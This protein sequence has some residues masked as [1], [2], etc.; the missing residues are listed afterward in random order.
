M[1]FQDCSCSSTLTKPISDLLLFKACRAC[2]AT[3]SNL[4]SPVKRLKVP[5]SRMNVPT[6]AVHVST[7][8]LGST[9]YLRLTVPYGI[10]VGVSKAKKRKQ[11]KSKQS[12]ST[13]FIMMELLSC[14][15]NKRTAILGKTTVSEC[16]ILTRKG[17]T[18]SHGTCAKSSFQFFSN[19]IKMVTPATTI[20]QKNK[21][22]KTRCKNDHDETFSRCV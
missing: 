1:D 2:K 19:L 22:N 4:G 5:N 3:S 17:I 12:Y 6:P 16:S 18:V 7:V 13:T 15:Q 8:S 10:P 20:R 21:N 14:I 11:R 9:P